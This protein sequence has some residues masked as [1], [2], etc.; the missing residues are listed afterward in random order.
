MASK[1]LTETGQQV[2]ERFKKISL[3][4]LQ[5][6]LV[7]ASISARLLAEAYHEAR[8]PSPFACANHPSHYEAGGPLARTDYISQCVMNIY[9][10][11][12]AGTS[13][14]H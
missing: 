3:W 9:Y 5:V 14:R 7:S 13:Q 10:F 2:I 4:Q 6:C 11:F 12:L 1:K 8:S